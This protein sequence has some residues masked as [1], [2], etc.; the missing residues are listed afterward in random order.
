M[1]RQVR[2]LPTQQFL[3]CEKDV[4]SEE[5]IFHL[6]MQMHQQ[7]CWKVLEQIWLLFYIQFK[8]VWGF[9]SSETL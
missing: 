8:V 2:L 1:E 5:N 3:L 7:T 6:Q 9:S 4:E